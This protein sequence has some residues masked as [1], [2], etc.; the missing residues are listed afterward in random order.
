M[1]PHGAFHLSLFP[2]LAQLAGLDYTQAI[3]LPLDLLLIS[4]YGSVNAAGRQEHTHQYTVYNE[5]KYNMCKN[6]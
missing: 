3:K 5:Q 1:N 2:Q 6:M 4:Q